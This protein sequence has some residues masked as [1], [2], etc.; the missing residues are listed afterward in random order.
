MYVIL[1]PQSYRLYNLQRI[2][3]NKATQEVLGQDDR[4]EMVHVRMWTWVEATFL[5][6]F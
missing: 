6:I 1:Q 4:P 2:K 3:H 5:S